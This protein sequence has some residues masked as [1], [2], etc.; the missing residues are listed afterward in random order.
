VQGL[1]E[2]NEETSEER[3]VF[4]W[5]EMNVKEVTGG[6]QIISYNVQWDGG[7]S[8]AVWTHLAG[9]TSNF[10][11]GQ[12]QASAAVQAGVTYQIRVRA[13]NYWGWGEFSETLEMKASSMPGKVS[14]PRTSIYSETGGIQ[15]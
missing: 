15:V 9:F 1:T 3:L 7:S 12:Y 8:G 10:I 11:G 2:I 13:K 14:M 4:A 5:T 6:T